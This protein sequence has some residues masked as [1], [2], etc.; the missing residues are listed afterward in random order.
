M[1]KWVL[2]KIFTVYLSN[3][4]SLTKRPLLL[5]A[6]CQQTPTHVIENSE[7]NKLYDSVVWGDAYNVETLMDLNVGVGHVPLLVGLAERYGHPELIQ[8]IHRGRK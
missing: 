6:H 8:V 4:M 5:R 7:L 1:G 3:K 2:K